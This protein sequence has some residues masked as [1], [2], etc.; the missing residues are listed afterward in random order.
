MG[1]EVSEH[2]AD[3]LPHAQ[4]AGKAGGPE[5]DQEEDGDRSPEPLAQHLIQV[6]QAPVAALQGDARRMQQLRPDDQHGHHKDA[7][8]QI[9][10]PIVQPHDRHPARPLPALGVQPIAIGRHGDGS[11]HPADQ[12][13]GIEDRS[14]RQ[15]R[16]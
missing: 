1:G 11:A 14:L 6:Q 8:D 2:Q 10:H 13:Q 5:A 3:A 12:A 16:P 15:A 9:G 4:Q 7:R